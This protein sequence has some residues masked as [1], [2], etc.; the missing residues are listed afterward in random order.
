MAVPNKFGKCCERKR[1]GSSLRGISRI[2]GLA[3]NTVVSMVRAASQKAQLVHNAGVQAVEIEDVSTD[4]LWLFVTKNRTVSLRGRDSSAKKPQQC[5]PQELEVGDCWIGLSLA[6][7]SG[8]ILAARAGK[9]TDELRAHCQ[10]IISLIPI[11]QCHR[12]RHQT[13]ADQVKL[14]QNLYLLLIHISAI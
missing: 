4:E 13:C 8:L 2:T 9:H 6:D 1:E 10:T 5:Y 3:Y 11:S 7:S 14:H 12:D